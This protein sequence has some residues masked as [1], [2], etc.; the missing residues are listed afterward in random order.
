[1]F[2]MTLP[3]TIFVVQSC[4]IVHQFHDIRKIFSIDTM[5]DEI[6]S[7]VVFRSIGVAN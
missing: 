6:H 5:Y 3:V 1:M 7:V 2:H 4:V